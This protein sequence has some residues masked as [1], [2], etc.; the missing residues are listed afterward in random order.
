MPCPHISENTTSIGSSLIIQVERYGAGIQPTSCQH[1]PQEGAH[2]KTTS[3]GFFLLSYYNKRKALHLIGERLISNRYTSKN[4][5]SHVLFP[6]TQTAYA[7]YSRVV[8]IYLRKHSFVPPSV[9][10]LQESAPTIIWV[11]HSWGLPR[12]TLHVS[13]QASSLWHFQEVSTISQMT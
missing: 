8:I 7:S 11:S 4:S 2:K 13:K 6:S 3:I 9:Q 10:F 5:I 12:S 1:L